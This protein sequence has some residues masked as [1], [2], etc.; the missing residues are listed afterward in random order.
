[1]KY[2]F[3]L[4]K[5]EVC[6]GKYNNKDI[7]TMLNFATKEEQMYRFES[8]KCDLESLDQSYYYGKAEA[9]HEMVHYLS[10]LKNNL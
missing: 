10:E 8:E 7:H 6:M 9:Y 1:M 3:D 5:K 4:K 2:G